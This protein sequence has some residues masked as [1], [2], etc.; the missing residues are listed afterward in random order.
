MRLKI[1]VWALYRMG[2]M[3]IKIYFV[4]CFVSFFL[5]FLKRME[6]LIIEM[7]YNITQRIFFQK[8]FFYIK[9]D[10]LF[11]ADSEYMLTVF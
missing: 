5:F 2:V 8:I 11:F 4:S 6:L 9:F 10:E 7:F 1:F 3:K